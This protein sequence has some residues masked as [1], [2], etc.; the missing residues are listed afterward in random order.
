MKARKIFKSETQQKKRSVSYVQQV[1]QEV[2]EFDSVA[3]NYPQRFFPQ[4]DGLICFDMRISNGSPI[5]V[6]YTLQKKMLFEFFIVCVSNFA[7]GQK[8]H[9]GS[10]ILTIVAIELGPRL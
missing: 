1:E 2:W 8:E 9:D 4:L 7:K 10:S 5:I 3:F 6:A